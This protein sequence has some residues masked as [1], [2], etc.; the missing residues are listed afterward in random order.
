MI[1]VTPRYLY[2]Q[3]LTKCKNC[4]RYSLTSHLRS[5]NI[6]TDTHMRSTHSS[7]FQAGHSCICKTRIWNSQSGACER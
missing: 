4:L 7:I 5:K 3:I 6:Q 2:V 1:T